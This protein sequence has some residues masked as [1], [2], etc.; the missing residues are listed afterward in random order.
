VSRP[1]NT[2][3]A[4]GVHLLTLLAGAPDEI[5]SSEL[6]AG[7]AGS[8]PVHAR[9]LLGRLRAAGLVDSRPGVKG[10]W[11][12]LRPPADITL[13]DVWRAVQGEDPI[14][15]LHG[16]NPNCPVGRRIQD[17]LVGVDRR[18]ARA[19]EDELATTTLCD[20][21]RATSPADLLRAG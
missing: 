19:V 11:Q 7:S 21:A 10:G 15:G 4:L 5:L 8:N 9:R 12:L 1:T 3:F 6:L 18:A 17:A 14:L 13:A 16:A 2:Q 20:L